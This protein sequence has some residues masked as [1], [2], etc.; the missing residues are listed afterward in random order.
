MVFERV[1]SA[2]PQGRRTRGFEVYEGGFFMVFASIGDSVEQG[3]DAFFAW[4][5]QLLGALV[6]LLIG[7]ILAKIIGGIVGKA[8]HR[9]GLDRSLA[10]GQAGR[11]VS[12]V[13]SSPSRLVGR[14]AFWAIF[15]GTISLAVTTLGID[16]LQS[17]VAAI[18]AYLPNVIAAVLIFLVASALAAG[19]A[20]L[21]TRLMGDTP[22]GKVVATVAPGL[23]MAIAVFMILDQLEIAPQIVT[24]TYAA[25]M[26]AFALAA[27]LAFGLGGREVA[28]R[29]L[30]GAYQKGQESRGQ[31][32]ADL[33][34]GREQVRH[35]VDRAK[36]EAQARA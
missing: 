4:L 26:G 13:T 11:W 16:A 2:L 10:Q 19:I 17:F 12:K 28:A 20:A 22:T 32:R 29:M 5:P 21:V 24:I 1:E 30:E 15:I 33:E 31:V 34:R 18:Y 9:A 23:V 27:A 14:I 8:L 6:I 7:Y 3:F 35:D 36:V 25:L